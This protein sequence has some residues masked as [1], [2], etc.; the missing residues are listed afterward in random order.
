MPAP[1]PLAQVRRVLAPR[2]RRARRQPVQVRQALAPLEPRTRLAETLP[3]GA[4]PLLT[5][6]VTRAPRSE[7]FA[8]AEAPPARKAA[9][10]AKPYGYE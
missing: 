1:R 3:S 6:A 10:S 4:A 8:A 5:V 7:E 2:E 9:G